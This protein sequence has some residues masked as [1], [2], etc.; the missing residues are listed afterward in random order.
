M[1]QSDFPE[2]SAEEIRKAIQT[3]LRDNKIVGMGS[4][5]STVIGA[6][7]RNHAMVIVG[8]EWNPRSKQCN[9]ILRNS[10]GKNC[11]KGIDSDVTCDKKGNYFVP[12]GK[13][14]KHHFTFSF[15]E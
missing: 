2:Q 6:G 1:R 4:M 11:L 10:W 12:I 8:Q 7:D 13:V 3:A 9:I 15:Y 14:L 5:D